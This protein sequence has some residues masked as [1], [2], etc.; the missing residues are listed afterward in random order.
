VSVQ[1]SVLQKRLEN[2]TE[3]NFGNT[4]RDV[5]LTPEVVQ[6]INHLLRAPATGM[7]RL[8]ASWDFL[9]SFSPETNFGESVVKDIIP[10]IAILHAHHRITF[11]TAFSMNLL[12]S[13]GVPPFVEISDLEHSDEFFDKLTFK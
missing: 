3:P 10:A 5:D 11:P 9:M 8:L 7:A 6:C 4:I 2:Q 12:L 1:F 13:H